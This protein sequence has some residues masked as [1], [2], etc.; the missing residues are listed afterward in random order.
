V[1]R[2]AVALGG[3][4][5]GIY[6]LVVRGSLT[7]DLG[8]GR[9]IR[10]LGPVTM[11]I[12]AP[13]EV[14]FDVVAT[15]Y[16]GRTTRALK[17]K[18]RVVERSGDMALAEHFT[19]FGPLTTTTLETVRFER[20]ERV[21]FRLVRGPV[22]YVIEQFALEETEHGTE[23]R[24]TGELGTDLWLAGRIWGFFVAWRWNAVVRSSL[25]GVK[26]EAERQA[27]RR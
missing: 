13:R 21:H 3:V 25:A 22:P 1:R 23:L 8:V 12:A 6:V 9:H 26:Q 27:A 20:P 18:L 24:Y 5:A 11:S 10:P 19:P 15:P 16:L 7:L 2:L 14:V 4:A 17:Q